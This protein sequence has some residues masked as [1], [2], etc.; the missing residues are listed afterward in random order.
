LISFSLTDKAISRL[1][2]LPARTLSFCAISSWEF[3]AM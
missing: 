3:P 1:R 2:G